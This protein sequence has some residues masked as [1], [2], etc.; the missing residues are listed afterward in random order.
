M[1]CSSIAY[2]TASTWPLGTQGSWTCSTRMRWR[3]S[4]PSPQKRGRTR[5]RSRPPATN[6]TPF[7]PPPI[8]RQSMR[9]A[10][11]ERAATHEKSWGK[12]EE[13]CF[14]N[15]KMDEHRSEN[16]TE[17]QEQAMHHHVHAVGAER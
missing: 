11:L 16:T 6:S 4:E 8:V 17:T 13:R 14:G 12:A 7:S 1:L 15:S 10:T 3:R 9:S 2:A 5:L